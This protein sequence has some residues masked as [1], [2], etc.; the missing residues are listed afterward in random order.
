MSIMLSLTVVCLN[1]IVILLQLICSTSNG[2]K[3]VSVNSVFKTDQSSESK[4][5]VKLWKPADLYSEFSALLLLLKEG[6]CFYLYGVRLSTR[7]LKSYE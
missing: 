2:W 3:C 7:L 1:C 6:G 5:S 4:S